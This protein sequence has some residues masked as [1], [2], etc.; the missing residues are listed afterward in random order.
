MNR[1]NIQIPHNIK[2]IILFLKFL[3]QIVIGLHYA[4]SIFL[5]LILSQKNGMAREWKQLSNIGK[6]QCTLTTYLNK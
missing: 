4:W 6:L 2:Q 1:A 5:V 3:V